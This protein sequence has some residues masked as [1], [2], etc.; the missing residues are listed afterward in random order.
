MYLEIFVY[1]VDGYVLINVFF[2][3]VVSPDDAS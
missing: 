1:V 3:L 2:T